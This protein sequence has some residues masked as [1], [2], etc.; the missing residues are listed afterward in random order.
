MSHDSIYFMALKAATVCWDILCI[1]LQSQE[2]DFAAPP[3]RNSDISEFTLFCCDTWLAF[4][5]AI[6]V[7]VL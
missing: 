7:I 3:C 5:V 6:H 1:W 4:L 2:A